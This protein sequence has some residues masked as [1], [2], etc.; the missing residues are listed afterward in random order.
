MSYRKAAEILASE[1]V[2]LTQRLTF[3]RES[4]LDSAFGIILWFP[5]GGRYGAV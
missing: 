4:Y 5:E 1:T 3:K 2:S